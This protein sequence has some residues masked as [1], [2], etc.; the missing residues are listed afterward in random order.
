LNGKQIDGTTD[1]VLQWEVSVQIWS[2]DWDVIDIEKGNNIEAIIAGMTD[3][4][5]RT[6]KETS[7]C[8]VH[9]EMGNG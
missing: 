4:K 2:F 9:T 7:L 8:I 6:E 1:E 3:A 5:S